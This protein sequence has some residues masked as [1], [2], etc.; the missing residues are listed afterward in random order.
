MLTPMYNGKN[1]LLSPGT[2]SQSEG[3]S[4]KWLIWLVGG[5]PLNK[6]SSQWHLLKFNTSPLHVS[7]IYSAQNSFI[8][9]AVPKCFNYYQQLILERISKFNPHELSQLSDE[10]T[11]LGA[12][13]RNNDIICT[14][15]TAIVGEQRKRYSHTHRHTPSMNT[16][17]FKCMKMPYVQSFYVQQNSYV[18]II[19]HYTQWYIYQDNCQYIT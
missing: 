2:S 8:A 1:W 15:I 4:S 3:Y 7:C 11:L 17:H 14:H 16:H 12:G 6:L 9:S 10:H 5:E 18:W 13:R 19:I